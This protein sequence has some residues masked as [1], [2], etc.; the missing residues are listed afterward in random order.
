[1]SQIASLDGMQGDVN[2][3]A[4]LHVGLCVLT[5]QDGCVI[6]SLLTVMAV[7]CVFCL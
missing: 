3:F 6:F 7:M 2:W 4:L 1:M 5:V